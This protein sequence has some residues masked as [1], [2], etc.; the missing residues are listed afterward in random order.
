M[1]AAAKNKF[2]RHSSCRRMA[3]SQIG[4]PESWYSGAINWN[5]ALRPFSS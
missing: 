3:T 1:D 5:L 2:T 4:F